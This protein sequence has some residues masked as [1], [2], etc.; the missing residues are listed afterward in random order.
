[1]FWTKSRV[2]SEFEAW[3]DLLQQ[4][5]F[6]E[7]DTTEYV[8]DRPVTYGRGQLPA[9]RSFLAKRWTWGEGKVRYFINCLKAEHSII[10]EMVNGTN[11]ITICNYDYYN[12]LP[13]ANELANDQL[14]SHDNKRQY[15]N[16]RGSTSS[17]CTNCDPADD[18][19]IKKE[20]KLKKEE[21]SRAKTAVFTPP[22]LQQVK[23]YALELGKIE[24][25]QRFRDFYQSKGWMIGRSKMRDWKAALRRWVPRSK[26]TNK[27][28]RGGAKTNITNFTNSTDYEQF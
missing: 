11:I 20:K 10:S 16:L 25:S 17:F 5:R 15:S 18:H 6:E 23:D 14:L 12:P 9:S 4:A 7:T 21:C 27:E 26:S 13:S 24:E 22:T 3:L 2:F 28:P 8:G 19:N 1:M